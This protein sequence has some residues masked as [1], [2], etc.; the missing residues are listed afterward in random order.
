MKI[1]AR[2]ADAFSKNPAAEMR[3]ILVHGRDAGLIHE[4]AKNLGLSVVLDLQDPFQVSE[5]TGS[6]IKSDPACLADEAAAQSL[7]GGRR[8]VMVRLGG[9][10]I[11]ASIKQVLEM[12]NMESLVIL[13]AG[14][15]AANSP[16][17]KLLEKHEHAASLACYEDG[18]A[19]LK[20][21]L[22]E[23]GRAAGIVFSRDASDYI[24][25]HLGSDRLVTR[26]EIEKLILYAGD[27][28]EVSLEDAAAVMGDN[29]ALSIEEMIY[30]AS[31]G[32]RRALETGF[33]RSAAE[34]VSPIALVRAAQRHFQRLHVAAAACDKG[35]TPREAVKSLRP[36]VLF[37]FEERFQ[38]QLSIWSER[39]LAKALQLLTDAESNCK[40]T[41]A[42][43]QAIGERALLR[44]AQVARAR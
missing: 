12:E 40:S 35:K 32:N 39:R 25:S 17:R 6:A 36:P 41:G 5:L 18:G 10:D 26:R 19:S 43:D 11:S 31:S 33:S 37:M 23:M 20:S 1:T 42:P 2:N 24:I 22:S 7:I 34:G 14:D 13:E 4:R 3:V 16:V 21:L 30:A 44:L 15:L 9:E 27:K 28:P 38:L 29:G 8:V